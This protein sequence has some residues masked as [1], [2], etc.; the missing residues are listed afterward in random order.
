MEFTTLA[1]QAFLK[2]AVRDGANF[3]I[4][5]G[6][7]KLGLPFLAIAKFACIRLRLCH[8]EF[9]VMHWCI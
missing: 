3:S 5:D 9:T 8:Y 7:D 2:T 6:Y 1:A 4:L